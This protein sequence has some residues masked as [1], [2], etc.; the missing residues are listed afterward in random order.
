[1]TVLVY[2]DIYLK[3][4]TGSHPECAERLR[5]VMAHLTHSK[6]LKENCTQ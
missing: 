4:D 5:V 3:H 6:I 1:M 2:D